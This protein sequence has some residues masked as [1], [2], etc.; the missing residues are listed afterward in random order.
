MATFLLSHR[1]TSE[2]CGVAF[3]AWNGY[4]SPLRDEPV[5]SSCA[6]GDHRLWWLVEV[7]EEAAALRMLPPYVASRTAA[8]EVTRH[9][10]P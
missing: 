10:L 8:V 3:A 2:E 9:R 4:A 6:A 7:P 1:H 5:L